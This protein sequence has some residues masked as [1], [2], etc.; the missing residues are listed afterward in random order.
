MLKLPIKDNV[1]AQ[2]T[3]NRCSVLA[4]FFDFTIKLFSGIKRQIIDDENSSFSCQY[5]ECLRPKK[6]L[7]FVK[8][9]SRDTFKWT[10]LKNAKI[11]YLSRVITY[12]L[13]ADSE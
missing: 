13:Y 12:Y 5:N 10:T 11:M 6:C 9:I 4:Y 1:S 2:Q 7:M 3:L 8:F